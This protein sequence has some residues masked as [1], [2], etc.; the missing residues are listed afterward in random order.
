MRAYGKSEE[1]LVKQISRA[2][3]QLSY[4]SEFLD[5]GVGFVRMNVACHEVV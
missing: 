2:G 1:E 4:G 5:G 3:W